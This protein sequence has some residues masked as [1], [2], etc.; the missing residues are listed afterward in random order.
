M[1]GHFTQEALG[2]KHPV[3]AS[4]IEARW[5]VLGTKR[6]IKD[7]IV[8]FTWPQSVPGLA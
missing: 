3:T 4:T 7:R 2:A 6:G 8:A 5:T 1:T